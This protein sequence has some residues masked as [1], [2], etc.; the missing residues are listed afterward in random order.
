MISHYGEY[1]VL[2]LT[3]LRELIAPRTRSY[4]R[5]GETALPYGTDVYA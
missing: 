1:D 4:M 5:S 2:F 3:L